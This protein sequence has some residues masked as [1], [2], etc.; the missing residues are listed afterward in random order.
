MAIA[1][2]GGKLVAVSTPDYPN[3][4]PSQYAHSQLIAQALAAGS[5]NIQGV[6]GATYTSLAFTRSLESA[7]SQVPATS[8]PQSL[9]TTQSSQ[10]A[11][12]ATTATPT[13]ASAP[14]RRSLED[15]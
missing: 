9:N 1:I 14:H 12:I 10:A 4:P 11:L 15:N 2:Q 7:L 6:S 13:V 3:S 5:A 8:Q